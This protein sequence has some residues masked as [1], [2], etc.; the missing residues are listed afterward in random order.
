M[1]PSI[2]GPTG[3][4]YTPRRAAACCSTPSASDVTLNKT[5]EGVSGWPGNGPKGDGITRSVS[6]VEPRCRDCAK[7][8]RPVNTNRFLT[9]A[10]ENNNRLQTRIHRSAIYPTSSALANIDEHTGNTCAV[11]LRK[12]SRNSFR[13]CWGGVCT[14]DMSK[15][16]TLNALRGD[17]LGPHVCSTA[18]VYEKK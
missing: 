6:R 18:G 15:V 13:A 12:C 16:V 11:D 14:V 8:S 17:S 10:S 3:A 1:K 4:R 7:G 9:S 2:V 5:A